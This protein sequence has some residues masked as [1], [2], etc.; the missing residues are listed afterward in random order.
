MHE[1]IK[2]PEQTTPI[3]LGR[4]SLEDSWL[5]LIYSLI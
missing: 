2:A 3:Q 4:I 1:R 5:N